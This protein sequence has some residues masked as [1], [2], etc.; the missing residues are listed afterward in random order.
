[1]YSW[2]CWRDTRTSFLVLLILTIIITPLWCVGL[3][4]AIVHS[5][6][7]SSAIDASWIA[8]VSGAF[9]F[10]FPFGAV[11]GIMLGSINVGAD[12]GRGAGNFLLTRPRTRKYFIWI[13]WTTGI[14]EILVLL[15]TTSL[16]A[17]F[18]VTLLS[19]AQWYRAHLGSYTHSW[20][21][22]VNI[23]ILFC[24]VFIIAAVIYGLTSFIGVWSR[25][26]RRAMAYAIILILA[27]SVVNPVLAHWFQFSL[28]NPLTLCFVP[29]RAAGHEQLVHII[30]W[31]ICVL[32]FPFGTQLVLEYSDV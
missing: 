19:P 8:L 23:P 11:A 13:N 5:A 26:A 17:F 29:S 28:P 4:N 15:V 25:S 32:A 9:V 12:M 7:N 3:I 2:K 30:G 20:L 22:A 6:A 21:G 18:S 1:M 27:Y 10:G 24:S 31:T 14:A 16:I